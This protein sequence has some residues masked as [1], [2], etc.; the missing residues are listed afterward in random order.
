MHACALRAAGAHANCIHQLLMRCNMRCVPP[1]DAAG[2]RSRL[3]P[4]L[5]VA[6]GPPSIRVTAK[7]L[8]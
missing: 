6:T 5:R 2:M 7:C 4:R 8:I 1:S 3:F